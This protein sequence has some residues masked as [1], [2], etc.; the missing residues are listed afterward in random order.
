V[1]CI[2]KGKEHTQFEFGNKNSFVYARKSGIT[3]AAMAIE[4]NIYVGRKLKP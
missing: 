3:V 1:L 4:E 2:S